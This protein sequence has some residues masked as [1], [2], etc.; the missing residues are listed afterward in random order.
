VRFRLP[1]ST[2]GTGT[3]WDTERRAPLRSLRKR[4]DTFIPISQNAFTDSL[5]SR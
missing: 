2:G 5:F 1:E 3:F 4:M